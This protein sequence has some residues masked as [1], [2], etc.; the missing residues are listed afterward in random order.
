M[1]NPVSLFLVLLLLLGSVNEAQV[2]IAYSDLVILNKMDLVT[3]AQAREAEARI[4]GINPG[5]EI[6][7]AT[8]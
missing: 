7:R 4:R 3:E 1:S 6:V 2:Q 8:K 5:V